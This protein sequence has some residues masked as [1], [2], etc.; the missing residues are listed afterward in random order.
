MFSCASLIDATSKASCGDDCTLAA[1]S[2]HPR[3]NNVASAVF[4]IHPLSGSFGLPGTLMALALL[5]APFGGLRNGF[6]RRELFGFCLRGHAWQVDIEHL[7]NLL[8]SVAAIRT[9][10]PLRDYPR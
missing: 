10:P 3:R 8:L 4:I 6:C 2:A 7:L 1:V 5:D 9:E